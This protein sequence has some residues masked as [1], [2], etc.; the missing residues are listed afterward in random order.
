[1]NILVW[2]LKQ[3]G[4]NLRFWEFIFAPV[5]VG[6][7][8][9]SI[10]VAA[11]HQERLSP[12]LHYLWYLIIIGLLLA[13]YLNWP[14]RS[15]SRLLPN[16]DTEVEVRVGD[17]FASKN[18]I[19]VTIPTTLETDFSSNAVDWSSIQGQFTLKYCTKPSNLQEAIGVAAAHIQ[20]F[21]LVKNFYSPTEEVRKYPPGEV[22]V[23]RKFSRVGYLLTFATYNDHGNAQLNEEDFFDLLPKLWLGVRDRGDV[24]SVD[25]PLIGAKFGRIGID[26]RREILRELVNSFSAASSEARLSDKVTFYIRPSDFTRWGFTFEYIERVLENICDDHRRRPTNTAVGTEVG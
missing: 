23:V 15:T 10:A 25:V 16:I 3:L 12:Y 13:A 7:T 8:L 22:F 11:G 21:K 24:G 18:P 2:Q 26:N 4:Q 20:N 6:W 19:V 14:K 17:I 9:T 5:G 1:M